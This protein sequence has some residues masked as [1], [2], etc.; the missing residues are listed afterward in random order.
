MKRTNDERRVTMNK[1]IYVSDETFEDEV[2][3]SE[4]PVLVDFYA[5]WC[6]P[7]RV[8][9]PVLEEIAEEL[10][11][12]LRVAKLN[13]D[14]NAAVATKHDV[15]SIPTLIFFKDGQPVERWVGVVPKELIL[16]RVHEHVSALVAI[17]Q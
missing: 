17:E 5:D 13:V 12:R 7:C 6:G 3:Q 10:E 4:I 9:S 8:I 11:G 15:Q 14:D 2:V 1:P 16:N